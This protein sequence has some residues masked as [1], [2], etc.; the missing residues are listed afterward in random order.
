MVFPT[1]GLYGL[2]ADAANPAAIEKVFAVKR[3]PP[4]N[5]LLVLVPGR[6]EIPRLV[7]EIPP[8]AE[9]VMRAFW[10]GKLT[11]IFKAAAGILPSLTA[12]TGHIGIRLPIHPVAQALVRA[13]GMPITATSANLSGEPGCSCITDLNPAVADAVDLILDAGPLEGGVGST[14]LDVTRDPPVILREGAVPK[15]MIFSRLFR[16]VS[17]HEA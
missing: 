7:Q 8:I 13:V 2:A 3:R 10:P 5:P 17:S 14:I 1:T 16:M 12:G 6:D 15:D 4:D 11:L 9:Q